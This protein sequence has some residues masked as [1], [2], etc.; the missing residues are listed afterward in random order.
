[1][2]RLGHSCGYNSTREEVIVELPKI[3]SFAF[4]AFVLFS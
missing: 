4:Y 2:W 3:E 1:M